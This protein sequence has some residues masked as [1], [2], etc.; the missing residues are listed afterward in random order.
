MIKEL[1]NFLY[2]LVIISTIFFITKYYF[3][4]Q[5]KKN[6]YRALINIDLKNDITGMNLPIIYSDTEKIIEFIDKDESNEKKK[7]KFWELIK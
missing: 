1:K 5:Y 7:F 4:D 6:Y 2:L 3:S